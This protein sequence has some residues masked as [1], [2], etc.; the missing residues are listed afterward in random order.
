MEYFV[1]PSAII[2]ENVQIGQDTKI[3]HFTHI[4]NNAKIGNNCVLGQNVYI[5]EDVNIGS[6]VKIQNN[7]SVYQG[8]SIENEVFCGPSVVFTND[9]NPRSAYPKK[10]LY[11]K[12]V[13]KEGATIGANATI[14][15]G[16][17]LGKACM[18]GAGAVVTKNVQSHSIVVGNPAKHIGWACLCGIKLNN[19]LY[20]KKCQKKYILM[21]K[22]LVI[23]S[24]KED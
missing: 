20:C 10:G 6:G 24:Q 5:G 9:L 14:I 22:G 13:V 1:H 4:Q 15:C 23:F 2:D 12:T 7:V 17:I 8:V 3:W 11:E 18:V 21:E 19:Q 16:I